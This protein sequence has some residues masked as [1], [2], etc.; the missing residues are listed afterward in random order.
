MDVQKAS[1]VETLCALGRR[2]EAAALAAQ[3]AAGRPDSVTAQ[4]AA[5]GCDAAEAR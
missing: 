3:F 2:A 4:V 1:R 5:E